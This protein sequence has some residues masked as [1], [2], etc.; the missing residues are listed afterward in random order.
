MDEHGVTKTS[1]RKEKMSL[2]NEVADNKDA[3]HRTGL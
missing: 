2:L 1:K 3:V